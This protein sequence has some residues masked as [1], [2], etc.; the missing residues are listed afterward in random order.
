M[1]YSIRA[2][3]DSRRATKSTTYESSS[4]RQKSRKFTT[5]GTINYSPAS[6]I[7]ASGTSSTPIKSY[8]RQSGT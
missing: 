2:K 4:S 7:A 5:T 6:K 1:E 8:F 3:E